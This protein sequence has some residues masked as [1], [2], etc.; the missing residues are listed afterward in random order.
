MPKCRGNATCWSLIWMHQWQGQGVEQPNQSRFCKSN[1]LHAFKLTG[2]VK[3]YTHSIFD[4]L[5]R[6]RKNLGLKED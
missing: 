6:N 4:V 5:W 1:C 2:L 3:P